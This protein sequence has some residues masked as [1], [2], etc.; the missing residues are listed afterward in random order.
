V[1]TFLGELYVRYGGELAPLICAGIERSK[2]LEADADDFQ[3]C[4]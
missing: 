2:F 3:G 1:R 4:G